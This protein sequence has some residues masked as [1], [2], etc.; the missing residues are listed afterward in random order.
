MKKKNILIISPPLKLI[1]GTEKQV[2]VV[3]KNLVTKGHQVTI[4][5][6][7]SVFLKKFDEVHIWRADAIITLILMKV[8]GVKVIYM[9]RD[10]MPFKYM[11]LRYVFVLIS[12]YF[13]D[14]IYTNSI[15]AI[16]NY[17]LYKK[18]ILK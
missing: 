18:I 2:K 11:K 15:N 8:M 7:R 13:A 3:A 1:G 12:S 14:Q 5:E 6:K 17:K 10:S 16:V 9:I 4:S